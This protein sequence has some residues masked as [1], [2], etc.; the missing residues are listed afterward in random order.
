MRTTV[1][2]TTAAALLFCTN[3]TALAK[4]TK[5]QASSQYRGKYQLK[6]N[7]SQNLL[8]SRRTSGPNNISG[9]GKSSATG[10]R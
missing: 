9:V 2:L 7:E 6:L 3:A 1:I 5:P 4:T 10:R 8:N